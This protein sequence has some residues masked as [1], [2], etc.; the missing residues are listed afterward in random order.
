MVICSVHGAMF[1]GDMFCMVIC[2]V[3][4]C[5]VHGDMLSGDMFMVICS[6]LVCSG[7]MFSGDMFMVICLQ[8]HDPI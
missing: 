2:S 6:V 1:S 8:E 4:I 5:S 7:D 3:V